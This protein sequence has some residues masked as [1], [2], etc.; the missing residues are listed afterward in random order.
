MAGAVNNTVV[1]M[2]LYPCFT[3]DHNGS[4]EYSYGWM[5]HRHDCEVSEQ[6][7]KLKSRFVLPGLVCLLNGRDLIH[8]LEHNFW[9]NLA[10]SAAVVCISLAM[11]VK[12]ATVNYTDAFVPYASFISKLCNVQPARFPPLRACFRT[13]RLAI[14]LDKEFKSLVFGL[15]ESLL[16]HSDQST[17]HP[18]I[19][20]LPYQ[21]LATDIVSRRF[22]F[23]GKCTVM[24]FMSPYFP[25]LRDMM[26]VMWVVGNSL[27]DPTFRPRT[28]M[29]AGPGDSG[30]STVL[31]I[32]NRGLKECVTMIPDSSLTTTKEGVS[33]DVACAVVSSRMVREGSTPLSG[34]E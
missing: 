18:T 12:D 25:D 29:L 9:D 8:M 11:G 2:H 20:S 17:L 19:L 21:P 15:C 26:T 31:N 10:S 7:T 1:Y 34:G 23:P 24:N 27:L 4:M 22:T 28:V 14:T 16:G 33:H 13:M 30:K 32:I 3:M 5:S 6:H